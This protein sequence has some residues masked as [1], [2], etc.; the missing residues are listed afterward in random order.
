[1]VVR[2]QVQPV[3]LVVFDDEVVVEDQDAV[4]DVQLFWMACLDLF[5][6]PP[7]VIRKIT[8]RARDQRERGIVCL[9]V[10]AQVVFYPGRQVCVDDLAVD[11]EVFSL[12]QFEIRGKSDDGEPAQLVWQGGVEENGILLILDLCEDLLDGRMIIRF[13]HK[14]HKSDPTFRRYYKSFGA[15]RGRIG[16]VPPPDGIGR[17]RSAWCGGPSP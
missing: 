13:M 17:R 12:Y 3:L 10:G 2:D 4:G 9:L 1:M 5:F 11:C 16:S 8:D 7:I 15:V 6:F 14:P